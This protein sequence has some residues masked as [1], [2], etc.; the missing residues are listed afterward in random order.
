MTY[1][2]EV[3]TEK[4]YT[5]N[6]V[7]K[8]ASSYFAIREPDSGLTIT[9]P[10]DKCLTSLNLNPSNID[11]RQVTTNIASYTFRLLDKDSIITALVLGDAAGLIGQ[12]VNIY[13]GRSNVDMDFADYFELP[14]TYINKIEHSD[15]TYVFSSVEPKER[16]NRP[17]YD[18]KSALAVDILAITTTWT[19]RDSI[20]DFPTSGYLKCEDEYVSYTGL[21]LLNNRITGVVR[22]EFNS[23]PAPHDANSDVVLAERI[24]DNP[25][26][27]ILKLLIS[28]GGGG[29]YDV[30][31]DGLGLDEDLIDIDEIESLRDELF[32]DYE[33][34]LIPCAMDSALKYIEDELLLPNNL[35]FSNSINSK[36]TLAILDKAQF[37]DEVDIINEDTITKFPKWSIDGTKVTNVIEID[38]DYEDGTNVFKKRSNYENAASIVLYGRQPTLSFAFK[39]IKSTQD[40]QA[41]V[42]DFADRLLIRLATPTP[43]ISVTTH[44][45]KSLQDIGDKSYLISTKVPAANGTLNFNS[46]L[47]IISRS[48]N[49]TNGEVQFSLA[50]TSY[51]NIRSGF[52]APSDLIL[53]KINQSQ[54]VITK[55]RHFQYQ[56]GMYMRLWDTVT[57]S[58]TSDLPNKIV[59]FELR[60]DQLLLEDGT[61]LTDEESTPLALETSAKDDIIVF[62]NDWTTTIINNRYRMKFCDYDDAV[63]TQKRYCFISDSGNNFA[64]GKQT[65]KVTY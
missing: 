45:D 23:I 30:L 11:I 4:K 51:T 37:V 62:E 5:G 46:D 18:Y 25:L 7:I 65:Y 50:Y 39:G 44:I 48:I 61:I 20:A 53:S 28:G 43:I 47:E 38:W 13:I 35:R 42:D 56:I 21:D 58:Y 63:D 12:A 31:K 34:T 52:I 10:Y 36:I 19:M 24:I 57:K 55:D 16:M 8:I 54:V 49:Q 29:T 40:G 60:D 33:Y 1:I 15:N 26:N 22:G 6:I 17:I 9:S 64:D 32:Y 3:K 27:I 59:S 2:D 14:V 41:L